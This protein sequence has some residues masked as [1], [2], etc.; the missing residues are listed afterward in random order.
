VNICFHASTV[1]F[2]GV[3]VSGPGIS[4]LSR[5]CCEDLMEVVLVAT[6]SSS[7]ENEFRLWIRGGIVSSSTSRV[8]DLAGLW[9]FRLLRIELLSDFGRNC[10]LLEGSLSVESLSVPSACWKRPIL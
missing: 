1:P 4:S 7:S 8:D 5:E 3:S 9:G 2:G 6:S 10:I